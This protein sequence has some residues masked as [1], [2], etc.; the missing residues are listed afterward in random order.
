VT[1]EEKPTKGGEVSIDIGEDAEP[2]R[3]ATSK[4]WT[5]PSLASRE[6]LL[7]EES[8]LAVARRIR[9]LANDK[10]MALRGKEL[11]WLADEVQNKEHPGGVWRGANLTQL[12]QPEQTVRGKHRLILAVAAACVV[13]VP[14]AFTW[15][16][17]HEAMVLYQGMLDCLTPGTSAPGFLELWAGGF[18]G[19]CQ[20]ATLPQW[21]RMAA[22]AL[23]DVVLIMLSILLVGFDKVLTGLEDRSN[24]ALVADLAEVLSYAQLQLSADQVKTPT[25]GLSKI[26][27]ACEKLIET[28]VQVQSSAEA[29]QAAAQGLTDNLQ[30][31]AEAS[32]ES[33]RKASSEL[34]ADMVEK[35]KL[36][37]QE[38]EAGIE[39]ATGS[40]VEATKSLDGSAQTV[41]TAAGELKEAAEGAGEVNTQLV[42][43]VEK[44]ETSTNN[45]EDS[46]N[47]LSADLDTAIGR[48]NSD[49]SGAIQGLDGNLQ[50]STSN[51]S[52]GLDTAI[53]QLNSN[54][55]GAIQGLDG[56][57]QHSLVSTAQTIENLRTMLSRLDE[58][59]GEVAEGAA[60]ADS[61]LEQ[62]RSLLQTQ[63]NQLSAISGQLAGIVSQLQR[64]Q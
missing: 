16:S 31:I 17:L 62:Y 37:N 24:E 13:F 63:G 45:L 33:L 18:E 35:Q 2:K 43:A 12:F 15:W 47:K 21:E 64:V 11:R 60:Q 57:L 38:L 55:S 25:D 50:T 41:S 9:I 61:G 1:Q 19:G 29:V 48:L 3:A 54:V 49:V 56:N 53:G 10:R 46:T 36:L 32:L 40:L 20:A 51:L 34:L 7:S 30:Q 52:A 14:I 8:R 5:P 27:A 59:L 28:E 4:Y 6:E 23:I 42:T 44:M 26:V 39:R 58:S 22:V